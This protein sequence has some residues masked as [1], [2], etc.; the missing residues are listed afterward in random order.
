MAGRRLKGKA[1]KV[2]TAVHPLGN[3]T[4]TNPLDDRADNARM[5][6]ETTGTPYGKSLDDPFG[7]KGK[8]AGATKGKKV[9]RSARLRGGKL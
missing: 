5:A 3:T 1:S 4:D 6:Q 9:G 7:V 2:G 8:A